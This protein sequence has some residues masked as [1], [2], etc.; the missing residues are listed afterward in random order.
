MKLAL[1]LLGLAACASAFAPQTNSASS[2]ALQMS[3]KVECFG[4]TPLKGTTFFLGEHVW[5]KLTMDLGSAETGTFLRAAELKHGR[6]AMIAT[7]GFA[8]EKLGFTFD[9]F[10]PHE[11]L[12]V[13][14]GVKFSDLAGMTPMEAFKAMPGEGIAQIFAVIAAIEIYELTHKDGEIKYGESVAP[15]LQPGGL[16][17]DL[18]W[19]PLKIE[20]TDRRRLSELQNG[21]AAMFAI[22]AWVFH[23]MIPGSVPIMLPWE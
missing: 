12:S 4:A 15:G 10:T 18:G 23:D 21:R 16:S 5:D 22:T 20:V 2:T 14:E 13:T 11:Y 1:S 17:G 7:V 19:N 8:A 6:S 9:K 3:E